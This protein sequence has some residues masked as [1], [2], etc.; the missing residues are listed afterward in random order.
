M[1]SLKCTTISQ[2]VFT[3]ALLRYDSIVPERLQELDNLRYGDIPD[4]IAQQQAP[5]L[6]KDQVEKLVEWKLCV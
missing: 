4:K 6:N 2:K 5:V 1:P 3:E